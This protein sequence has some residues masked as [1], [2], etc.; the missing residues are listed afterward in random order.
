VTLLRALCIALLLL[1]GRVAGAHEIRPAYLEISEDTAGAVRIIWRKPVAGESA[2]AI[3]PSLSSGWLEAP[4]SERTLEPDTLTLVWRIA[5]PHAALTGQQVRILGLD[6]TITDVF[7][8]IGFADGR[9]TQSLIKAA[10]PHYTIDAAR[11]GNR[12][13]AQYLLLGVEHIA[14][15]FDHLLYLFALLLLISRLP[16]LIATVSAFT[17]AHS[18]TLACAALGIVRLRSAPVEAAISLSIAYVAAELLQRQRGRAGVLRERPWLIALGFGLL[19]GFGFAGALR[20]IGLPDGRVAGALFA[21]NL[22][23]EA[24]QLVFVTTVFALLALLARA[25]PRLD[26]AARRVAPLCIGSIAAFWLIQR[27]AAF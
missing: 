19:H 26:A 24:G 4:P 2:L 1:A 15:G 18:I 23:I 10:Q 5:P 25:A 7:L 13:V 22:G 11:A 17:L 20:E 27:V 12:G 9:E 3:A 8:R 14:T 21:F 16:Q 6:R